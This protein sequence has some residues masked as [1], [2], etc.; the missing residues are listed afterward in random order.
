MH[1]TIGR[2]VWVN[3][4]VLSDQL[5]AAIVAYVHSPTL[6]NLV[7]FDRN[8][9]ASPQMRVDFFNDGGGI[10]VGAAGWMPYQIQAEAKR[11]EPKEEVSAIFK[12][13]DALEAQVKANQAGQT[14]KAATSAQAATRGTAPTSAK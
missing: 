11:V 6:V 1:P 9:D 4:P 10:P 12:R 2:V 5:C 7:V 3:S 13:L 14:D 8:G